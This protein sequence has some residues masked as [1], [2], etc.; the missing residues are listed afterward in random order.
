MPSDKHGFYSYDAKYLDAE[1]ALLQVPADV[2]PA[3][4]D[5][6]REIL[7]TVDA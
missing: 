3:V 4:A 6:I 2:P 5:R 1:G 7:K